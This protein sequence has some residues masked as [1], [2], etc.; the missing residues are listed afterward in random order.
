MQPAAVGAFLPSSKSANSPFVAAGPAV[1]L[2]LNVGDHVDDMPEFSSHHGLNVERA[3]KT[4]RWRSSSLI[5]KVSF[6]PVGQT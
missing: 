2:H 5:T 1:I 3:T 6:C 4:G